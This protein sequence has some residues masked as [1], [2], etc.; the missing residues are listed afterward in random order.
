M[1]P[2]S[3]PATTLGLP[4]VA[5]RVGAYL[6]VWVSGLLLL[7]FERRNQTVR[8]HARQSV[9]IFGTLSVIGFVL[10]GLGGVLHVIPLLGGLLALPF[11]LM[12]RLVTMLTWVLW[13]VMMV[14]A[15][16]NPSFR[17]PGTQ[18]LERLIG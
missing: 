4:E 13:V 15:A 16:I 2:Y 10:W 18:R 8:H 7:L 14:G 17:L 1:R 3:S 11:D 9:L 12:G 6:F 5:E